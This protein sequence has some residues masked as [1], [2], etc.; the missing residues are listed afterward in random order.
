MVKKLFKHE[1]LAYL[2]VWLPTQAVLLGIA[3]LGRVIQLF[4][5]DTT[6]Y[7][8]VSGSSTITYS[9]A[10]VV[11][12]GLTFIFGIVRFYKNLFTNEG[13]LSFTLPVTP[14]QHIIV[15]ALTALLFQV[16]TALIA[17][18]SLTII[19]AGEMLTE[20]TKAAV[21][22][23]NILKQVVGNHLYLYLAEIIIALN[24]LVLTAF[25]FYYTCIS[26]GQLFKKNRVLA[27]VGVYF[28]FYLAEQ[29]IG[30]IFIII[31][32]VFRD[33][34]P[35]EQIMNAI[36]AH[37]RAAAHIIICGIMLI[38]LIGAAIYFIVVKTII[39]NR[40]NLE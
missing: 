16:A 40:L 3:L 13:Y 18:L 39:K 12:I 5:T 17:I 35:I 15:K 14:S 29:I 8:I 28:G 22:L 30:T 2:R 27:A 20:L 25:L 24:I 1:I 36:E 34:L 32:T 38:A 4:E 33:K 26:I 11:S 10:I 21:Y 9:I 19:T 7:S 23:L 31:I 37:P 6:V